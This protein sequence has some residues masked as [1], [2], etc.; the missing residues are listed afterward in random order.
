M[1]AECGHAWYFPDERLKDFVPEYK[2]NL[3]VP[4]ELKDDDFA[5]FGTDLGFLLKVLNHGEAGVAEMLAE[6]QYRSVDGETALLANDIAKLGLE[7]V[8]DEGGKA[9]IC[10]AMIEHD[11]KTKAI[12]SVETA[13]AFMN[14]EKEVIRFVS[15]RHAVSPEYV[16]NIMKGVQQQA[17]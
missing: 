11:K 5:K 4:K 17:Q 13:R 1:A 9:D 12:E 2:L 10:K 14:D 8:I 7:I 15:G 16:I 3:I 6:P